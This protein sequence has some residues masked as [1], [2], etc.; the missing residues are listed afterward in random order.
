MKVATLTQR[1]NVI[2]EPSDVRARSLSWPDVSVKLIN[3]DQMA[4]C[5]STTVVEMAASLARYKSSSV[6]EDV[7]ENDS[8]IVTVV[9]MAANKAK[10]NIGTVIERATGVSKHDR[11]IEVMAD[12]VVKRNVGTEVEMAGVS[13]RDRSTGM[14]PKD[15]AKHKRSHVVTTADVHTDQK[16]NERKT[17]HP[18][19]VLGSYRQRS[20]TWAG[21]ARSSPQPLKREK[22]PFQSAFRIYYLDDAKNAKP[23]GEVTQPR[24][25]Y[26]PPCI[27][28]PDQPP[29]SVCMTVEEEQAEYEAR[30]N[31]CTRCLKWL[32][33]LAKMAIFLGIW[34]GL[35][36]WF[37]SSA[38]W[39][40]VVPVPIVLPK[41]LNTYIDKD[42]HFKF[43]VIDNTYEGVDLEV[44][45]MGPFAESNVF[46]NCQYERL[47]YNSNKFNRTDV[48]RQEAEAVEVDH[49]IYEDSY[50]AVTTVWRAYY[51]YGMYYKT[52]RYSSV[53]I[54]VRLTRYNL[55]RHP[56]SVFAVKFPYNF[57]RWG[58]ERFY[59]Y[60]FANFKA[61]GG[62]RYGHIHYANKTNNSDLSVIYG[63]KYSLNMS[64]QQ[65][66][67]DNKDLDSV[68]FSIQVLKGIDPRYTTTTTTPKPPNVVQPADCTKY[69]L[70]LLGLLFLLLFLQA[71]R[72]LAVFVIGVACVAILAYLRVRPGHDTIVTWLNLDYLFEVIFAMICIAVAGETGIYDL[73][74]SSLYKLTNGFFAV[75]T[76]IICFT[77]F[78]LSLLVDNVVAILIMNP[79]AIRTLEEGHL[80][81]VPVVMSMILYANIA[82]VLDKDYNYVNY[83]IHYGREKWEASEGAFAVTS[84]T[85]VMMPGV[86]ICLLLTTVYLAVMFL[87]LRPQK[88]NNAPDAE[89]IHQQLL[90]R[91]AASGIQ[92][93]SCHWDTVRRDLIEWYHEIDRVRLRRYADVENPHPTPPRPKFHEITDYPVL[94]KLG[95]TLFVFALLFY[96][97]KFNMYGLGVSYIGWIMVICT[98][99]LLILVNP[100]DLNLLLWKVDWS[101]IWVFL[102]L[103]FLEKTLQTFN[104]HDTLYK[105]MEDHSSFPKDPS[106]STYINSV[107]NQGKQNLLWIGGIMSC[108]ISN[109]AAVSVLI[110]VGILFGKLVPLEKIPYLVWALTFGA[111]VGG[112]GTILG[113]GVAIAGAASAW[114]QGYRIGAWRYLVFCL[115]ITILNILALFIYMNVA[116]D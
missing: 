39:I 15:I 24:I 86:G 102:C 23:Y 3:M 30:H 105:K 36:F 90:L 75:Y 116:S 106:Q 45:Y 4:R 17:W 92:R 31:Y 20:N 85:G 50:S 73:V 101:T 93:T 46:F 2:A 32:A 82:G 40:N 21:K 87:F 52:L 89:M 54:T 78:G 22:R 43:L 25:R 108:L 19:I 51:D 80:N 6:V 79:L 9:E 27:C 97:K 95:L 113:T 38:G 7:C 72:M 77:T 62:R 63:L 1:V 55:S 18:Q 12:R 68:A 114:Q 71:N 49:R 65:A 48:K 88:Y 110:K 64:T 57:V 96:F 81:P 29:S 67:D 59:S 13:K 11:S 104:L 112:S 66:L 47:Y 98:G 42:Q 60:T 41:E 109:F 100:M 115:P 94:F 58:N 33:F 69:S 103:F 53:T 26:K 111:N 37:L 10:R 28:R 16:G 44:Q 8:S 83:A 5:N 70:I 14:K 99:L 91:M 76:T 107:M 34:S 61:V 56:M 35:L 74:S 84:Y